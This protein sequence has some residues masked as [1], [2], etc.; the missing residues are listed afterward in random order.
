[1]SSTFKT[2]N[3]SASQEREVKD[4]AYLHRISGVKF[5]WESLHALDMKTHQHG[6]TPFHLAIIKGNQAVL[7]FLVRMYQARDFMR[8]NY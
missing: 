7:R 5:A 4:E 6:L 1:M 8:E 2:H 3:R